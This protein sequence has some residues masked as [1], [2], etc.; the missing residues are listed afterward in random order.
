MAFTKEEQEYINQQNA[1]LN[2]LQ[3]NEQL[4]KTQNQ[5]Q[6]LAMQEEEKSMIKEQLDLSDEILN[7]YH[8]SK[9]DEITIKENGSEEWLP[10][11][12]PHL[13]FLTSYGVQFF[14]G[15]IYA[16]AN[17][18]ILLSNYTIEEVQEIMAGLSEELN[19]QLLTQ[20]EHIFKKAT[21]K[22]CQQ[23][24]FERIE[25]DTDNKMFELEFDEIKLEEEE[26]DKARNKIKN[27]LKQNIKNQGTGREL[28]KIKEQLEKDR[29]KRYG[30]MIL[31]TL[32]F[33]DAT[34]HRAISG[35]ERRSIRQHWHISE[36]RNQNPMLNPNIKK[37]K[38][39]V[40]NYG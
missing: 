17:K 40:M 32:N 14:M 20:Y 38:M 26:F 7:L 21:H 2:A 25:R 23:V 34:Y 27:E 10:S 29:R 31:K 33:I 36:S 4:L 11:E 9:G 30:E 1:D 22:E 12:N 19:D 35:Q 13:K 39:G 18:N 6:A 16:H 15:F 37:G 5:Q 8:F 3:T 28:L 24:M